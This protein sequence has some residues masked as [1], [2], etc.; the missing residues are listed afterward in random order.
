[1]PGKGAF[2]S[3]AGIALGLALN[4]APGFIGPGFWVASDAGDRN[5]VQGLVS[6]AVEALSSPL[7]AVGFQW[8]DSG[9]FRP[10]P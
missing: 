5:R 3:V 4:G 6:V 10:T 7:D 1:M 9:K 8:W 2:K